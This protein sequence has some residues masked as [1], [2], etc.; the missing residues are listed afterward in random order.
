MKASL[1][2]DS[3]KLCAASYYKLRAEA[4]ETETR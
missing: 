4:G 1:S 2:V 3:T